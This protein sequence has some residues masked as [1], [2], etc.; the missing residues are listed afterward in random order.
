MPASAIQEIEGRIASI[1]Q[2]MNGPQAGRTD[3]NAGAGANSF[4]SILGAQI[5][6]GVLGE[7]SAESLQSLTSGFGNARSTGPTG[8]DIVQAGKKYLGIPYVW[9]GTDPSKGLDCSGLIQVVF[10]EFGIS[11]PRVAAD[12]ARQGTKVPSL[13]QAK[14]GDLVAF[15]SPVD[16]IG[17]YVGDNKMLVAPRK[18]DVV[19]IQEVYKTPTA[20]RRI[21]PDTPPAS[22]LSTSSLGG[23]GAGGVGG[24][25]G[26]SGLSGLA[27]LGSAS[28]IT[29]PG[30]NSQYDGLITAAAQRNGLDPNLL[31]AV[32]KQE[33]G[34]NPTAKSSAGAL[35]LMQFMPATARSMGVNP[36]DP[37]S[38]I[39]GA[40][41]LLKQ[42]RDQFGGSTSLA[43]AGYNAG[44]GAVR[45][46][47]GIPPYRET[48]NYVKNILSMAGVR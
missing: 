33:S 26:A 34:F 32:A 21:I 8:N 43:L 17:I 16:H 7:H 36:L 25:G 37:T 4:S 40:A 9:G 2:R 3:A 23:I 45:K 20:I 38:A 46:H 47:G 19:K 6:G 15:G 41:R 35:G 30:L 44:P 29:R 39:D 24:L 22:T 42:L 5:A 10:K 13:A 12:Q 1:Q 27:G 11:L 18:G 14:P 28:G 48:Q 31:A